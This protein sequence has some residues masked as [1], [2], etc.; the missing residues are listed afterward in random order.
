MLSPLNVLCV[1]ISRR[2][3]LTE[4]IASSYKRFNVSHVN[5]ID[6]ELMRRLDL[7]LLVA[8]KVGAIAG[9]Q[10][11]IP[12]EP[13]V[14]AGLA[15]GQDVDVKVAAGKVNE[16]IEKA[17]RSS[18]GSGGGPNQKEAVTLSDCITYAASLIPHLPVE[19]LDIPSLADLAE[20][21]ASTA[22][23][24]TKA[25]IVQHVLAYNKREELIQQVSNAMSFF[26]PP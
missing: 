17:A 11:E 7:S 22:Q 10:S 15:F 21:V 14:A 23:M 6:T 16:E 1:R 12:A 13:G 26:C 9:D 4:L 24:E 3:F 25:Q 5:R 19:S 18:S 8:G 2:S 20:L